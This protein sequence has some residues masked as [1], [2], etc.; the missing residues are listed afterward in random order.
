[1][2]EDLTSADL[3]ILYAADAAVHQGTG[4]HLSD[5]ETLVLRG[6]L[7]KAK[8][9][10]IAATY[11]YSPEYLNKDI[12]NKLWRKLSAALGENVSKASF[13]EPVR[14]WWAQSAS[15]NIGGA[16]PVSPSMKSYEGDG[17][18]YIERPPIERNCC[19]TL[20]TPGGMV[21]IKAAQKMGKSLLLDRIL[22]DVSRKFFKT[23]KLDLK[24]ADST[25]YSD[26]ETFLKWVCT[27]T[28]D[29]L[30]LDDQLAQF[31]K[32]MYG[33]NQN[34]TR[35]FQR[36]ILSA[37]D[38]PLVLAFDNFDLLFEQPSI[39]KD[40]CRLLRGWYENTKSN[41]RIGQIWQR[42]RLV[43]VHSTQEYPKLDINHSPFNVGCAF[44]LPEFTQNQSRDLAQA[45][46]IQLN[47]GQFSEYDLNQ[48]ISIVGGHPYLI[49]S[50]LEHL[51]RVAISVTDLLEVAAMESS[52]YG[53]HLRQLLW[54]LK[55]KPELVEA[56]RMLIFSQSPIRL[57]S[58]RSFMLHSMGLARFERDKCLPSYELYRRYFAAR[59]QDELAGD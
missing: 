22:E 16:V 28:A 39:F 24:L 35:Y 53:N 21:R 34:T 17:T 48:L 27:N 38:Q 49:A 33:L 51:Q 42:L 23:V 12:G 59:L 52:L 32:P 20:L 40:F 14:R 3:E 55:A 47:S 2:D 15:A 30:D 45:Y 25:V 5:L 43:V 6:S 1:M 10:E 54:Q 11:G 18:I 7:K 9:S 41:D 37:L 29:Y 4:D 56:L 13:R 46:G 31:W 44:E 8:Y 58:Q 50:A 26:L 19:E 57:D 36:Y